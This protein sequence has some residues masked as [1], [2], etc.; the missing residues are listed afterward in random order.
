MRQLLGQEPVPLWTANEKYRMRTYFLI[1]LVE[2]FSQVFP[3]F[4]LTYL[5]F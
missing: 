2:L 3:Y 1:E 4:H 5:D